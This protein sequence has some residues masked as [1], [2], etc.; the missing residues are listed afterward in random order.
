VFWKGTASQAA[1]KRSRWTGFSPV[2]ERCKNE[3]GFNRGEKALGSIKG[4]VKRKVFRA[5]AAREFLL[6]SQPLLAKAA[7]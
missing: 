5:S 6:T 2:Y 1:E 4:D 3:R 7:L